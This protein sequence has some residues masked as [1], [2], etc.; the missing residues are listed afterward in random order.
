MC[1]PEV[2]KSPIYHYI[3]ELY[4]EGESVFHYVDLTAGT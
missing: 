3:L 4:E 1:V 2:G